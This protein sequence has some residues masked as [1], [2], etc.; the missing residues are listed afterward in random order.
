MSD[1]VRVYNR[2]NT[3]VSYVDQE[4][5]RKR[6]WQPI[7]NGVESYKDIEI[8]EIERVISNDWGCQVL[9]QEYLVIKDKEVCERLGLDCPKEYFYDVK[10]IKKILETGSD[11]ELVDMIQ[12]NNGALADL[13]KQIAIEIKLD[14][15]RK[16]QIIK[17]Q[18]GFDINFAI[19]NDIEF[20]NKVVPTAQPVKEEKPKYIITE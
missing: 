15:S 20:A 2:S 3:L 14:S 10:E 5:N 7:I 19:E 17:D 11:F 18:L 13:I 4:T 9:Y 6:V 12:F 8:D 16:R 1:K